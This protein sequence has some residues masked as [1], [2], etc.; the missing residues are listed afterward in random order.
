M[1]QFK[2]KQKAKD[3]FKKTKAD[4]IILRNF[5][6][7]HDPMFYYF[8]NLRMGCIDNTFLILKKSGKPIIMCSS[9]EYDLVKNKCKAFSVRKYDNNSKFVDALK[10]ELDNCK[11]IGINEDIYPMKMFT[12]LKKNL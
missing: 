6:G 11:R 10:K 12:R 9:L 1:A 3:L 2:M 7:I 8:T 5:S 4:A